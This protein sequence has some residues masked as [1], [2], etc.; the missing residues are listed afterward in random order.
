MKA[1]R[2]G[3][4]GSSADGAASAGGEATDQKMEQ[5]RELMFGGLARDFDRRLKEL[6]E[7]LELETARIARDLEGRLA[8][9]EAR[10]DPQIEKLQAQLRQETAARTAGLDDVDVRFGH[11]MRT[12]RGEL[13]AVLQQHEDN[14][15]TADTRVRDALAQLDAQIR[16]ELQAAKDALSATRA[17]LGGEK[18][19]REDLADLMA[20]LSLRLRG[21]QDPARGG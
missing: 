7:R 16:G 4:S 17:E 20:E 5:I 9:L 21:Q 11:A 14:A 12:H 10:L 6:A 3:S 18:L 2:K 1:E 15:G 13:N 19:A 8:A